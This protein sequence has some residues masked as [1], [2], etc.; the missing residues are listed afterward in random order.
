MRRGQGQR[1]RRD[2][3]ERGKGHS[4]ASRGEVRYAFGTE[5]HPFVF[6]PVNQACGQAGPRT[7][8]KE[9]LQT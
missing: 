7:R 1:A 9:T 5:K 4:S 8:P 3:G 6:Q 2:G